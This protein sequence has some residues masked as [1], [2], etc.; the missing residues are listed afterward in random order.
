MLI[1]Q[2]ILLIHCFYS[3]DS[4]PPVRNGSSQFL[5]DIIPSYIAFFQCTA[6][7]RKHC[8]L[9]IPWKNTT[10]LK[11]T[12]GSV[13][14]LNEIVKSHFGS[15]ECWTSAKIFIKIQVFSSK[16]SRWSP[17]E[18]SEDRRFSNDLN[19]KRMELPAMCTLIT[20]DAH[21]HPKLIKLVWKAM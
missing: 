15:N 4:L 6:D 8:L 21:M 2:N 13:L 3:N 12:F 5:H 9:W 7:R 11:E 20:S 17:W 14:T 19:Q 18:K 16:I 10:N 1:F